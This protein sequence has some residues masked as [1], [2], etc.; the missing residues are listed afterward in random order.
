MIAMAP[1]HMLCIIDR[2]LHCPWLFD[3]RFRTTYFSKYRPHFF[4]YGLNA[5]M[6]GGLQKL[7]EHWI[8]A[9]CAMALCIVFKVCRYVLLYVS[10][11]TNPPQEEPY[12]QF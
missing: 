12:R 6:D 11:G 9:L 10:S 5:L 7:H 2:Q 3:G 8:G 4:P 1:C